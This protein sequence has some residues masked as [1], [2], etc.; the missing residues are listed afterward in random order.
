MLQIVWFKRD[1]RSVD[2]APLIAAAVAGPVLPFYCLEPGYWQ[3][4]DTS[5]RQ[6][7]FVR[8]SL[9]D[10]N[11]QLGLSGG[12]L[13]LYQSDI[14]VLLDS[15]LQQ[16]GKFTLHSHEETGNLW[17]YQRD[18]AV[19][20]WCRRNAMSWHQYKQFGVQRGSE[21]RRDN[22]QQWRQQW[23]QKTTA[24]PVESK[25]WLMAEGALPPAHWPMRIK[26]DPLPCPRRQLGGRT[27][28]LKVLDSF[29]HQ[30]GER[31]RGS[32]SRTES[33]AQH[34]SRL[35][36]HL[37]FGTLSLREILTALETTREQSQG[38]WRQSLS[39]FESR[40]WWHC[41]F[42]QKLEAQPSIERQ[43]QIAPLERLPT[44]DDEQR[45][46]AWQSGNTGWPMVDA[47]MRYLHCHGWV[48][49]RMRAMLVSVAT[50][51]LQLPW[52][53]VAEFLAA[54]FVDYE[55]G[56]HYPQVQMQSG[57]SWNP[58]LRIYNPTT[59]TKQL[60]SDGRFIRRWVPELAN[61]PGEWLLEPWK[62]PGNLK[63][64][65]K[66]GDY[67]APLVDLSAANRAR[68][69]AIHAIEQQEGIARP[70]N[71]SKARSSA[72]KKRQQNNT[73]NSGDTG[74]LALF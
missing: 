42:I 13:Y 17:T 60:D 51:T 72:A 19:A 63:Q 31:Y 52:Q 36:A 29:L 16:H 21:L 66:V 28:G 27:A 45:W 50:H 71:R 55:P 34:G 23:L 12:Q 33:A 8:E 44:S 53:R 11:D 57:L 37:A 30:R 3:L 39:A 68:K 58:V 40:L 74:Q 20:R 67:P 35:S 22:W 47:A 65:Y 46:L 54:Q 1:L 4:P 24:P 25:Q 18:R 69:A 41:H 2:H 43:A 62:L 48:N 61:L 38:R 59:Q 70:S 6:W 32:L 14:V 26:E 49:F 9:Q 56:I 7:Q 10:L 5:D 64:H 15:L 73:G